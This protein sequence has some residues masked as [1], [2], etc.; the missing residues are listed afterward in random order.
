MRNATFRNASR[1][2]RSGVNN[3]VETVEKRLKTRFYWD[4]ELHDRQVSNNSP[5]R[6]ALK[7]DIA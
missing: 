3:I 7:L 6:F 2:K 4:I 5:F 1:R